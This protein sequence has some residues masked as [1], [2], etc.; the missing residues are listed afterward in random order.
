MELATSRALASGAAV[1][2]CALTALAPDLVLADPPDDAFAG[3]QWREVATYF[4]LD[5]LERSDAALGHALRRS[6]AHATDTPHLDALL[7]AL[8]GAPRDFEH[9]EL[10]GDWRCRTIKIGGEPPGVI[11]YPWFDCRI[12]PGEHGL[13]FEKL[14]GSQRTSGVIWPEAPG[15]MV[16]LGAM[17]WGGEEPRAYAGPDRS[18]DSDQR[19][20]P[21]WVTMRGR[22]VLFE[23]PA[24]VYESEYNLLHL[25]RR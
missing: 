6:V 3:P 7:A 23:F 24:P 5:R 18:A 20:D 22:D 8:T 17:S 13:F 19:N 12:E 25:G 11:A 16:Y 1:A 10:I 15:R 9:E 21:A 4:D 14:T 2:F